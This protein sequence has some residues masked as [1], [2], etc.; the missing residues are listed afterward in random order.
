MQ[1]V[2]ACRRIGGR[3][4]G[5]IWLSIGRL[6]YYKGLENAVRALADV[7]GTL[8]IV[9]TGPLEQ[10]LKRLARDIGV[11]ERIVWCGKLGD[12]ALAVQLTGLPRLCGSRAMPVA[13]ALAWS[14]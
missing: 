7:P 5:P 1:C 12:D 11:S 2:K 8:L 13:K 6:V 10:S 4:P 9:G 3:Y 14:R